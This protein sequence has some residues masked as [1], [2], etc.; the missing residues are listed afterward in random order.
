MKTFITL[1]IVLGCF[2]GLFSTPASAESD[3]CIAA[4]ERLEAFL[5]SQPKTCSVD[6]DCEGFFYRAD[7]CKPAIILPR[8]HSSPEFLTA[9]EAEQGKV[10]E[11]CAADW[12]TRGPCSPTPF[13]AGCVNNLCT[14]G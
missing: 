3:G 12:S 8:N 5:Q 11:A 7:G 10:R 9:L 6:S 1:T 13:K 2:F 14:G 4:Q